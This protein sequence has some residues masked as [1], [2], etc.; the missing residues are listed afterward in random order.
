MVTELCCIQ[1]IESIGLEDYL[2][3]MGEGNAVEEGDSQISDLRN[4]A[5]KFAVLFPLLEVWLLQGRVGK[6]VP[7]SLPFCFL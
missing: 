6:E 4:G 3:V 2:T 1:E 7:A 5:R